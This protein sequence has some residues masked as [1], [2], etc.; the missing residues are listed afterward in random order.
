MNK[1][2]DI[3][4]KSGFICDMDGVIYHGNI[5][6]PGVTEFVEWLK[7]ENKRSKKENAAYRKFLTARG[8][9]PDNVLLSNL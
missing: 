7:K 5:L 8:E 3:N 1:T 2:L 9:N 4:T 6:L